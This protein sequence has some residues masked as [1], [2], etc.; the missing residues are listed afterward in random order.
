[1]TRRAKLEAPAERRKA[2]G[3]EQPSGGEGRVPPASRPL[4]TRATS[5]LA[6]FPALVSDLTAAAVVG[7]EP[8]QFRELLRTAAIP[9]AVVGRRVIAPVEAVIE[10]VERLAKLPKASTDETFDE[11]HLDSEPTV[12]QLLARIGRRR[13]G[14]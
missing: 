6:V 13:T 10:A 14:P 4:R 5:S 9:H 1:M 12:D 2:V 7:L 3:V 11:S 8:R